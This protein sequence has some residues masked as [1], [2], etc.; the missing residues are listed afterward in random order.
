MEGDLDFDPCFGA[1]ICSRFFQ[2]NYW[3]IIVIGD[4]KLTVRIIILI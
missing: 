2:L 4:V 3:F 1:L